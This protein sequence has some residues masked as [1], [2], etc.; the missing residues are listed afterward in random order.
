[1]VY[2]NRIHNTFSKVDFIHT[3]Q[4]IEV[5]MKKQQLAVIKYSH[6]YS[7]TWDS[8]GCEEKKLVTFTE[9]QTY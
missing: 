9:R 8:H 2:N 1:M 6:M 4:K 7:H 5:K 3:L